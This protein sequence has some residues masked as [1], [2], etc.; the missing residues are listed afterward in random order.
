MFDD[1]P[2]AIEKLPYHR[3]PKRSFPFYTAIIAGQIQVT[4]L[5]K[6]TAAYAN[7]IG[8]GKAFGCGM[9]IFL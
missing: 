1:K 8:R 7:G 5:E 2:A 6:F 4:D 9:I 3:D